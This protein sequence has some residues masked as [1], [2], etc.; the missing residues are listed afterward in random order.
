MSEACDSCGHR[1]KPFWEQLIDGAGIVMLS[2]FALK[3]CFED[4]RTK[5]LEEAC[6]RAAGTYIKGECIK[7]S[8]M[9]P[10]WVPDGGMR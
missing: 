7:S 3:G 4:G 5:G 2:V 8:S 6:R 1:I 9:E 10:V